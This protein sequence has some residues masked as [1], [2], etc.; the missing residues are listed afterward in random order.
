MAMAETRVLV[1]PLKLMER[2]ASSVNLNQA[3]RQVK[4][5]KGSHGVDGKSVAETEI[6]LKEG[7]RAKTLRQQ[8]LSGQYR[9]SAIRGV[10]IPKSDG[11]LR[12]LGIPTVIDRMIQQAIAQE[13]SRIYE[14]KFSDS[15]FGFRAGRSAHGA[16]K[17]AQGYVASGRHYVVDMDLEKYFDTVNHDRLMARL[18]KDIRDKRVLKLIRRYLQAGLMQ[19]GITAKRQEGTPQG[20]PLSPLLANI[21]LDELDKEL[22]RRGHRFCRYAD[23]CNIYVKSQTAG[24]RV[25]A[26][27]TYFLEKKLKLKVN[28]NKSAA[29][30]VKERQFLGYRLQNG[31]RLTVAPKSRKRFRQKVRQRTKRSRG[32]SLEKVIDQLNQYLRGWQQYFRL[33]KNKSWLADMDSWIRRRLRCYRLKQRKRRYS[34][35]KWLQTLGIAE[36]QAWQLAMSSKGLWNNSRNPVINHALPNDWFKNKGLYFLSEKYVD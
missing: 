18:S 35:A 26:S 3:F 27:V 21:V 16:L 32:V 23:D 12:Q 20:G 5:N 30:Q 8:L 10:Q 36:Q 4:R 17:Q 31:G 34:I 13:L 25:L 2:I 7:D 6:Y 11:G 22:E 29:A 28:R 24:E 15:S 19:N 14:P 9:P 33:A 1:E